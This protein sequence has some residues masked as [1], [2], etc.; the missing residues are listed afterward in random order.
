MQDKERLEKA[1]IY[2]VVGHLIR[3]A[4]IEYYISVFRCFRYHVAKQEI[5]KILQ[6]RIIMTHVLRCFLHL[7]PL[8]I[9][10]DLA[11]GVVRVLGEPPDDHLILQIDAAEIL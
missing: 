2:L 7:S 9:I 6:P 4:E 10:E 5:R 11:N 8:I 3:V 1:Y